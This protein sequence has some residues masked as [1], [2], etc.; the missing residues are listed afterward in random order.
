M[1]V[2]FPLALTIQPHCVAFFYLQGEN[3]ALQAVATRLSL[4]SWLGIVRGARGNRYVI[5]SII[6]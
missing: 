1:C 4:S 6:V 3:F 5:F 2:Y